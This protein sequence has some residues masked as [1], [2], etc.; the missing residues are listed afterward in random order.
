MGV[1]IK[2]G[3]RFYWIWLEGQKKPFS[4]KIPIGSG[5]GRRA[6]R[7]QAEDI[8]LAA[9]GDLA[10]G[11]FQLPNAKPRITFRAWA[12]WYQENVSDQQR[13]KLRTRSMIKALIAH[14]GDTLLHMLDTHRIDEWKAAR[15]RQVKPVTVNRELEVLKPLL[16]KAVPKYLATNPADAVRRFT[17]RR[18]PITIVAQ[19]AEDALLEVATVEERAMYLLGTDA[20]LRLGDVRRLRLEHDHGTH[21]DII[22]PKTTPYAVPVSARLRLALDAQKSAAQ[23]GFFFPRKY[24][25]RWAAMNENTAYRVF[26]DLCARANV[27]RG[28]QIGGI[29]FHSTRHTGA[30]RAARSVKLSVVKRLGNWSSLDMLER[31]DHPDDPELIRAV[32][33]IGSTAAVNGR[34]SGGTNAPG[35]ASNVGVAREKRQAKRA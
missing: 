29:T 23:A 14:F 17:V 10:R 6:A 32:E 5:A 11:V 24:K 27:P 25:Q 1:Y 9:M 30:T 16:K 3:S 8:Y 33:A 31:Y 7:A 13:S 15:A 19:S 18:P 12:K 34:E 22:D 26:V 35:L 4:S 21:L 28:R 2:S 20:L